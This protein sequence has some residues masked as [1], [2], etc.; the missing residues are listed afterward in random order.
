MLAKS[1]ASARIRLTFSPDCLFSLASDT[2]KP[3]NYQGRVAAS[4]V[5]PFGFGRCLLSEKLLPQSCSILM[6]LSQA[7]N[8]EMFKRTALA[9]V[10]ETVAWETCYLG[11]N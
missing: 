3:Q 9:I 11:N 5:F 10:W 2:S 8:R 4:A 7:G 1:C 6:D